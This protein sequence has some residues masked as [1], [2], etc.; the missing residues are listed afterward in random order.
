[1]TNDILKIVVTSSSFTRFFLS[2][3]N[4]LLFHPI[5]IQ[6]NRCGYILSINTYFAHLCAP[7]GASTVGKKTN[8][9]YDWGNFVGRSKWLFNHYTASILPLKRLPQ[10]LC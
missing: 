10:P 5:E 1:M 6:K 2:V 9:Q 3:R 4:R 8:N 7:L